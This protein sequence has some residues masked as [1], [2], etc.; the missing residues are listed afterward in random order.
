MGSEANNINDRGNNYLQVPSKPPSCANGCGFFG[1]ADTDNLCSKCFSDSQRQ[2]VSAVDKLLLV[3]KMSA[4]VSSSTVAEDQTV[5]V[6]PA[7]EVKLIKA[8][9][10]CMTCN[11]KVGVMGFKCK[12]GDVFCGSHRYPEKHDCDFDFKKTG[13]DAISKANPVIIADKLTRI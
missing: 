9:N 8:S 3:T 12:C 10:R 11:K 6:V 4:A 7:A 1:S 5:S 2:A 13:R